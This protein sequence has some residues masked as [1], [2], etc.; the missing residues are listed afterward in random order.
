[1]L[2]T[3]RIVGKWAMP[4]LLGLIAPSAF[5]GPIELISNGG[6]ESGDFSGWTVTN[7]GVGTF[8]LTS[9]PAPLNGVYATVGASEGSFYAV[10]SQ[11]AGPDILGGPGSHALSQSFFVPAL[12]TRVMFSFDMFVQTFG[13]LVLSGAGL[14]PTAG[15][16][17]HAR[18]DLM[19]SGA[20]AFDTS[21]GVLS[22]L[23]VGIDGEPTQP[24]TSYTFD[25][26]SLVSPGTAYD[27]RFAQVAN[28]DFFNQG[29]DN[30][31]ILAETIDV[32]APATL[33]L[34]CLGLAGL[35]CSRHKKA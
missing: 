8:E 9:E 11:G 12:A 6:F 21:A 24:Y 18:V 32:S 20:G 29:V 10:S 22:N 4:A 16:N 3:R 33:T 13:D 27:I 35:G 31:S 30:V 23:Y 7:W 5:S 1:M 25:L 26:T 14:D 19:M 28:L 2:R 15:P 34:F 17:Q